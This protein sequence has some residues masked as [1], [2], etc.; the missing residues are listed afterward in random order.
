VKSSSDVSISALE[1]AVP[2]VTAEVSKWPSCANDRKS[3]FETAC[4]RRGT[5]EVDLA[6][7]AK[8]RTPDA[9]AGD[10]DIVKP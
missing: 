1:Y 8:L 5:F 10:G 6:G 2:F 3:L 9:A 4:G 7:R